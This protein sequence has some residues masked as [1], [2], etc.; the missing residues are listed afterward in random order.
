MKQILAQMPGNTKK[1]QQSFL[2]SLGLNDY[3]IYCQL[4]DG[5]KQ[6]D[7][8]CLA[9]MSYKKI[10]EYIW[11]Y[12]TSLFNE[13]SDYC[14]L[15]QIMTPDDEIAIDK[16][17]EKEIAKPKKRRT[18]EQ[19]KKQVRKEYI[20][21]KFVYAFKIEPNYENAEV[22]LQDSKKALAVIF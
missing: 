11:Q 16:K 5:F 1:Q 20:N 7:E 13:S 6:D 19:I 9:D 3:R 21:S 18:D 4:Y 14:V 12:A 22:I 15:N 10:D 2:Y 17:C 8:F